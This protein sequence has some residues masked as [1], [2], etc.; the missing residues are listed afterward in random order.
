MVNERTLENDPKKDPTI[1]AENV[2]VTLNAHLQRNDPE[3]VKK[4]VAAVLFH[5]DYLDARHA[6]V[7]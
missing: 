2:V 5:P 6:L 7:K 3:G 1:T 4:E